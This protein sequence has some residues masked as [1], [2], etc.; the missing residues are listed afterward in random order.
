MNVIKNVSKTERVISLLIGSYLL[1]KGL[2]GKN[3]N[4]KQALTGI[5]LLGRSASG[6]CPLYH[7]LDQSGI[8]GMRKVVVKSQLVVSKSPEEVYKVWRKL[9][10]LPHFMMHL[11]SVETLD[12]KHSEW[13]LKIP[14][15][16][17]KITWIAEITEDIA[18]ERLSWASLPDSTI[19][20]FGTVTFKSVGALGTEIGVEIA[21]QAP[22]GFLGTGIGKLLNPVFEGMIRE[23]IKDFRRYVELGE[24]P[25]PN[26][27]SS[28][29]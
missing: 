1:Y 27:H 21:Y 20:N 26:D 24:L 18:N 6:Y 17:G 5:L 28:I 16:P 4:T 25:T 3:K 19:E 10:N 15:Y 7:G 23:D 9:D 11:E 29:R 14:R 13:K 22:G 2:S 12:N 8:K